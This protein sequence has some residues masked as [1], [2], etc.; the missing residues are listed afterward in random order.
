M[1]VYVYILAYVMRQII[2]S[3]RTLF[4]VSSSVCLCVST[5][6]DCPNV[7]YT[8]TKYSVSGD[9][10]TI[11]KNWFLFLLIMKEVSI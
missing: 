11:Y 7:A 9:F 10:R 5:Q 8:D 6:V 4:S 3:C 1:C 2:N